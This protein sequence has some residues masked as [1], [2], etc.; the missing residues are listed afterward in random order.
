MCVSAKPSLALLYPAVRSASFYFLT[1]FIHQY[2]RHTFTVWVWTRLLVMFPKQMGQSTVVFASW[3]VKI[4]AACLLLARE[5]LEGQLP[6]SFDKTG[7]CLEWTFKIVPTLMLRS[8]AVLSPD[9]PAFSYRMTDCSFAGGMAL[10][11]NDVWSLRFICTYLYL[12]W[13]FKSV[14]WLYVTCHLRIMFKTGQFFYSIH[15]QI[16]SYKTVRMHMLQRL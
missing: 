9:M 7:E 16:K 2:F 6:E 3:K 13:L 5:G 11:L 14:T 10:I 15:L 4:C 1:A 8:E 12:F